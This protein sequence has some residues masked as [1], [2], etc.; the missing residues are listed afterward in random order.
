MHYS[1]LLGTDAVH[2]LRLPPRTRIARSL[3]DAAAWMAT[4][5]GAQAVL[6]AGVQQRLVRVEHLAGLAAI[7]RRLRRR[8]LITDTLDDIAGGVRALS[9]LD[10]TRLVIR[11]YGL[12]APDRQS[13]R[14]D[15]SGR[16]R[17]L[18]ALW[19]DRK[20]VVEIDGSQHTDP[21]QYWDDMERDADLQLD[22]YRVLRFPAW[23]VRYNPGHV[24]A[25][26]RA[27]LSEP[28]PKGGIRA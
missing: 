24:A 5:R 3:L 2:P 1:S 9:E 22:G 7:N 28:W 20:L 13:R 11:A 17:Y 25:K 12:P 16:N 18:D 27:A 4:D 23:V 19:E 14:K 6:A 21:W 10:F 26:V 15:A 8:R